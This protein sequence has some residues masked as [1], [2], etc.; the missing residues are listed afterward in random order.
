MGI[1]RYRKLAILHKIETVYGTDIVPA[2]ADGLLA[3]NVTFTPLE[4]EEVSRDL[5]LPYMGNQGVQLAG[6]YAR[7]EFDLELAGSGTAGTAPKYA[8][9]LR[10]AG[11]AQTVTAGTKTEYT[12]V[13]DATESGSLYFVSEKVQHVLLGGQCNLAF[14]IVPKTIP[15]VRV[16]YMGLLGTIT[17]IA[18]MPAVS[19]VGWTTP[20]IV[21]KANTTM[22]LHGWAAVAESLSVDLGNTVTPRFLI[23][24]ERMLI[25]DRKSTSTAVVEARSLA[26]IDWFSKAKSRARAPLSLVHG[27]TAGNIVELT[28]PAVEIGKPTQGQT[29]GIVNYSLPLSLCPV[30]GLDELKII[31]R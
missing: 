10:A 6:I 27:I 28:A 4:G 17:D 1:R 26:E 24:D 19:Q 11:L 5:L 20:L 2:A 25:T 3:K 7:L 21:S 29:D 13:E 9:I 14:N 31:I 15:T 30:S 12:I 23:G 22:S 8:S 18:S 16:T